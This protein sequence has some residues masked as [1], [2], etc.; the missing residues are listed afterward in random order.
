MDLSR[1]MFPVEER[2][3]AIHDGVQDIMDIENRNSFL[4]ADYKALVRA[5]TN[6]PISI[7]RN[8][9]QVVPNSVLINQLMQELVGMDTPFVVEPSHSF[10]ANNKMRLQIKFPELVVQ[11]DDSDIALSLYLHNSYDGSEGVRVYFG[12]IRSICTNGMVFGVVVAKAY[13]RHTKGF[14]L[15]N[16]SDS[17]SEVTEHLPEIQSRINAL[18]HSEPDGAL[19]ESVEKELGKRML[20]QV[21]ESTENHVSQ[22]QVLNSI[23]YIISHVMDQRMRA[24]YQLAASRVFAL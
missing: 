20:K 7:V 14:D 9:Y 8:T 22:W 1:F 23:T 21:Q 19:F 18:M 13:H 5:D 12:A 10:V 3:I 4:S 15:G 17:L 11:D 16:I 2:P 24:R 6:E